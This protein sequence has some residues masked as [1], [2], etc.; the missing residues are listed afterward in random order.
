VGGFGVEG[1]EE[2]ADEGIEHGSRFYRI[3]ARIRACK[4][5]DLAGLLR[6]TAKN[7]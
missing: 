6:S 3:A 2:F 4:V 5:V 7:G 1:E